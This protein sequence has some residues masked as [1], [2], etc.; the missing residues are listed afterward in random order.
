MT[1]A[2]LRAAL[3]EL[4]ITQRALAE[5]LGVTDHTVN[6]WCRPSGR[7]RAPPYVEVVLDLLKEQ[8]EARARESALQRAL[9]RALREAA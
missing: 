8:G 1:A 6:G 7:R 5:L 9:A 2:E 4:G 3:R